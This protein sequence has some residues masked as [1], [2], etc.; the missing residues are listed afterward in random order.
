MEGYEQNLH[1][2]DS[3]FE[4]MRHDTDRVL[5][6][7]LK[8]MVEKESL[9]GSVTIKIDIALTQEFITNTDPDIEGETRR[10][11]MPAFTHKVGSVVQIKDE[12]KGGIN[13]EGM[14][15][16]WDNDLK[17]FVVKPIANT[18]QRTIF[19]ADFQCVN[20]PETPVERDGMKA[21]DGGSIAAL[22]GPSDCEGE[23]IADEADE[24]DAGGDS[25]VTDD[26][27]DEIFGE[28][29]YGYD[30]MEDF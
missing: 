17:E 25:E 16:V 21:I 18:R 20:D 26:I 3:T 7:L 10:V 4:G 14:E 9:E 5:Q 27:S 22:P 11:L 15:M 13:Y 12:A 23:E 8:N 2:A 1:I 30:D 6:K 24:N 28:D 19:D 29:D